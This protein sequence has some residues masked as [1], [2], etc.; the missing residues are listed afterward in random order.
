M[1]ELQKQLYDYKTGFIAKGRAPYFVAMVLIMN[2]IA[3]HHLT[4]LDHRQKNIEDKIKELF[5][6]GNR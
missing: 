6:G 2:T 5:L 1:R 3:V 4:N